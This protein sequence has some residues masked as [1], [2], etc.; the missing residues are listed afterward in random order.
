M[1]TLTSLSY[2]AVHAV[3]AKFT[4]RRA[5]VYLCVQQL[6]ADLEKFTTYYSFNMLRSV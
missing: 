4:A 3:V 1:I 6:D 2:S 5:C